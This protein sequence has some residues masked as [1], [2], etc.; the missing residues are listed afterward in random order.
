[1]IKRV[2][3]VCLTL[4]ILSTSLLHATDSEQ[5]FR[6]MDDEI[7]RSMNELKLGDLK[8][9][10]NIEYSLSLRRHIGVHAILGSIQD[11]DT[12]M[13]ATLSVRI[14][15]GTESFDNTN[16]FDVGLGFFGSS[17]DEESFRN[18]RIPYELSYPMLRRE[19]WL[20]TDACYKQAVEILAKK[21]AAIKNRTR[22]DTTPDFI[23]MP[24]ER[25]TDLGHAN[26]SGSLETAIAVCK[27]TSDVF[28]SFPA[29]QISRVGYEFVPEETF[30]AN[31]EGRRTHKVEIFTGFEVVASAQASDGMP[32]A[33]TYSAYTMDPKD[34]P[35]K[36]SLVRAVREIAQRLTALTTATSIEAYSGPVLFEGQAAAE[37]LAQHFTPNLVAQRTPLSDGG[38]GSNERYGAFQNKIGAR[39]LP[40]F[41][42][43]RDVPSMREDAGRPVAGHY[44]IDDEGVRAQDVLV[45]DKGF[46]RALLSSRV[47]TKRVK[48]TNGHQRGGGAMLSTIEVSS[49][50]KHRIS[51]K[52]LKARMMKL[53]K[54]RELPYGII[55]RKAL[56]QNLLFTGIFPLV[57]MDYPVPQGEAKLGLLEVY[58]VYA[59]GREEIVRGTEAAGLSPR[60]FKDILQVSKSTTV[61]NYLAPSV[62]PSF[63]TGG[64]QYLISTVITPDLLFE[65]VEIRPIE[66]DFPKPPILSNPLE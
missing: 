43:V 64:S 32:L 28:T 1:M 31:S 10:Y 38:F 49:D 24:A 41:L 13:T 45:V 16:F 50:A 29:I 63:M 57:G 46:L 15:V 33:E 59:D 30:Y 58:R 17:D 4:L 6:A 25:T 66:G 37:I 61:H 22:T 19:F 52:E 55:V 44:Q 2:A 20:A 21:E 9:P 11:I 8:R 18:R 54:D 47:P 5:V 27:A 56:N 39:V 51:S 53:V 14:R 48:S 62:I 36:D 23:S 65:D 60:M 26:V 7:Q 34:M 35:T 42:S 12:G 40:E 3:T